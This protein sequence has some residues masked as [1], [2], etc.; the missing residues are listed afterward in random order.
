MSVCVHTVPPHARSLLPFVL[1][2]YPELHSFID[3]SNN[4]RAV[5]IHRRSVRQQIF[6]QIRVFDRDLYTA[7]ADA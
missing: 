3:D 1:R 4:S 7:T 6:T 5:Y 2:V